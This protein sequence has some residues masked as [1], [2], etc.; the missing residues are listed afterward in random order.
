MGKTGVDLDDSE[1]SD[2]IIRQRVS[3]KSLEVW[4]GRI[5]RAGEEGTGR[6]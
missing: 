5:L 4:D 6:D 1:A 3:T 2:C